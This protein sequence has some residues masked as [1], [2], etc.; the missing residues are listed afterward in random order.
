M[1]TEQ[2]RIALVTGASRGIGK[3]IAFAL[4]EKKTTVIGTATTEEGAQKI[5]DA[6]KQANLDGVGR[7]LDVCDSEQITS[8]LAE[9][10]ANWGSPEI[11]VNNA[12]IT[13]DNI[14]LRMKPNQWD[15]V[16]QTNLNSIYHLTKA[17]LKPMFRARFGRIINISSVSAIM[18]NPGQ[19]NYAAAKA[20][21]IGFTKSLAQEMASLGITANVVAPGFIQTDMIK[22]MSE[23]QQALINERVPM[24]RVGQPEEIAA[25]VTFLASDQAAYITGQTLSVNGGLIMP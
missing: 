11:L 2:K 7:K 18:G 1:S 20:G 16:I 8:L 23:E 14:M 13:R 12:G 9:M 22:G 19:A 10:K 5:T 3:A 15:E 17:C 21:V 4:A 6:F 25:A 24:G